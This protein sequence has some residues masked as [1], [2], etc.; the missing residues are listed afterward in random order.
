[1]N[2]GLQT[3]WQKNG[4]FRC[5]GA[6]NIRMRLFE[7]KNDLPSRPTVYVD[8]D[9]VLA[10]F[11]GNIAKAHNVNHWKEIE[12]KDVA[13]VQKAKESNFFA[14]LPL[15]PNANRLIQ[16]VK[17]LAGSYSILSSPLQAN[18]EA[19]S[20]EKGAWLQQHFRGAMQPAGIVFDHEKFKY[21]KQADGTPNILIDDYPVNIRLW[22][23]HGGIG[24]T[25]KD[26][27]CATVLQQLR[28]VLEN[29]MQYVIKTEKAPGINESLDHLFTAMDVL[30]YVKGI[31]KRYHLDDPITQVK[32]WRLERMPTSFCSSPEFYHQ[33]DPYRRNIRLDME[34]IDGIQLKDIMTKPIVCNAEGW[35][36]DGNHRVTRA[37]ELGL[38]A[39][40]VLVPA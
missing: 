27:D 15:L 22:N 33:D 3:K 30:K 32:A 8:M 9:G 26:R 10:D 12:N 28:D 21:A 29:P 20:K 7:L 18:V 40:P 13:I 16:G 17:S 14:S 35:V 2:T 34:H 19:S 6:I 4:K 31:H 36:L 38:N 5:A 23:A 24:L 37:R 39:I 1:L 25:Y 11:F